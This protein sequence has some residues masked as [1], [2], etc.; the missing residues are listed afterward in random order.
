MSVKIHGKNYMTVAERVDKFS[1]D[2]TDRYSIET[3]IIKLEDGFCLIKATVHMMN[4]NGDCFFYNGHAY[5]KESSSHINKTS[6]IEN[7]ETS[8]IGRALASAGYGGEEFCSANELENVLKQQEV[9]KVSGSSTTK[10]VIEGKCACGATIDAKFK[11]CYG[12][13]IKG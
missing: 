11:Q 5:E 4:E 2:Y 9:N 8:A 3:E 12:C 7:C 1:K 13:K 10:Q 6:Y